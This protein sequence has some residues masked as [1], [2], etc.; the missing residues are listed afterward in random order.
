MPLPPPRSPHAAPSPSVV[1]VL[2]AVDKSA[3]NTRRS[4]QDGPEDTSGDQRTPAAT[5]RTERGDQG[6]TTIRRRQPASR[7]RAAL[8]ARRVPAQLVLTDRV[9]PPSSGTLGIAAE[10]EPGLPPVLHRPQASQRG[11]SS[12]PRPAARSRLVPAVGENVW[13]CGGSPAVA[14]QSICQSPWRE[15]G[16]T[17]RHDPDSAVRLPATTRTERHEAT[18]AERPWPFSQGGGTGSNPVG[19]AMKPQL[20]GPLRRATFGIEPLLATGCYWWK[21]SMPCADTCAGESRS[22]ASGLRRS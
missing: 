13:R 6:H 4:G 16:N 17:H 11:R 8:A 9:A 5:Q 14:C 10:H 21:G 22:G 12:R 3:S 1:H 7:A 18:R 20:S 19:A 15:P 2:A